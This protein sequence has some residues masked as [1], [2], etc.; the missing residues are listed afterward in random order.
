MDLTPLQS[1]QRALARK[2]DPSLAPLTHKRISFTFE[3]GYKYVPI[4]DDVRFE[5]FILWEKRHHR[6]CYSLSL[7]EL[8]LQPSEGMDRFFGYISQVFVPYILPYVPEIGRIEACVTPLWFDPPHG[9]RR[10]VPGYLGNI[11]CQKQ[12]DVGTLFLAHMGCSAYMLA[13]SRPIFREAILTKVWPEK[14]RCVHLL[15]RE[16]ARYQYLYAFKSAEQEI[17]TRLKGEEYEQD[18]VRPFRMH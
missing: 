4:E 14:Q 3:F 6:L 13:M 1:A 2:Y 7:E 12:E 15:Q 11:P 17:V 5:G 8:S 18:S 16:H 9:A 10:L